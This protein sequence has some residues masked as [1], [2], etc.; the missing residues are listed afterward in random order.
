MMKGIGFEISLATS[1]SKF[2]EVRRF[3]VLS[4]VE[5]FSNVYIFLTVWPSEMKTSGLFVSVVYLWFIPCKVLYV[6][7][8]LEKNWPNLLA[9]VSL[10]DVSS[11]FTLNVVLVS[12][13]FGL[14]GN[15][16]FSVLQ[17]EIALLVFS[18]SRFLL[19]YYLALW[20]RLLTLFL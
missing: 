17:N 19:Y 5:V 15:I 16:L 9:M 10:F 20:I 8:I 4:Y 3:R 2:V 14:V 13:D 12:F 7:A 18:C 1:L 11:L 6:V